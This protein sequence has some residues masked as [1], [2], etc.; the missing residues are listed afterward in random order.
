L[1][2]VSFFIVSSPEVVACDPVDETPMYAAGLAAVESEMF[3]RICVA[4]DG[5][6]HAEHALGVAIDL[7]R[8]YQSSLTVVAVAP[9]IPVF[10]S[11]TEPWVP[12]GVP[13]VELKAYRDIVDRAVGEAKAAG[14]TAVTGVCLEGV[15]VDE[16][17]THLDAHPADLV[18]MGSRGLSTAKRLLLG[19]VSESL[20]HHIECPVLLVRA[21]SVKGTKAS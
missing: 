10:V 14:L 13:D 18:V 16:L 12:T 7:A 15:I 8:R 1:R 11:P 4:V 21:P 5:S 3:E 6:A 9:L 17:V 2:S 20:L 19:S